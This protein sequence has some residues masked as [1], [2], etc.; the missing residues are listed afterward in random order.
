MSNAVSAWREQLSGWTISQA[1]IDAVPDSPY[2]WS[3]TIW[4]RRTEEAIESDTN[5][6]TMS[7]IRELAGYHGSILDVGAGTGRSSIPLARAGHQVT[8]VE[9]NS[10]MIAALKELAAGLPLSIIEGRWPEV[11]G[12]VE[13][14]RVTLSAHV[15]YD[16]SDIGPFLSALAEK[17][18]S[19]V[20]IEMTDRHPWAHLSPYYRALHDLERPSGPTADDM[21]SVI[22][23]VLSVEPEVI[24]WERPADL[25]FESIGEM[26]AFYGRRLV[27]PES[28]WPE[29]GRLL[30]RDTTESN[31]RFQAGSGLRQLATIWWRR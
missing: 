22:R 25:W 9:P 27:L 24:H 12:Q 6:P 26:V 28:R 4:R 21:V 31:G 30:E 11:V 20:V 15:V 10:S 5:S 16:V 18:K 13:Q 19:G 2:E 3:G 1:L 7:R 23:E 8:A 17:A 14:H 29:L